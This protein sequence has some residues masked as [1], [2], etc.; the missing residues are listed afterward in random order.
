MWINFEN[1][2]L[3]PTVQD[4]MIYCSRIVKKKHS[5]RIA[6]LIDR[7]TAVAVIRLYCLNGR[8]CKIIIIN[9]LYSF[10]ADAQLGI[11]AAVAE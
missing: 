10:H 7:R 2:S 9:Y 3:W 11:H 5:H 8:A 6:F 1:K 4:I